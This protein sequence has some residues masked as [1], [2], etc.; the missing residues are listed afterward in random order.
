MTRIITLSRLI[1]EIF[2]K[3]NYGVIGSKA[4]FFATKIL[5]YKSAVV[6]QA[7][8]AANSTP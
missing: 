1:N 3:N 5:D 7:A 6:P 8:E 4:I 2:A